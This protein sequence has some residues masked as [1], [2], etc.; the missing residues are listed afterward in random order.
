M[1]TVIA[2]KTDSEV[3]IGT[4]SINTFENIVIPELHESESCVFKFDENYIG[5]NCAYTIQQS[6][7][8]ILSQLEQ[9]NKEHHLSN[10][11]QIKVFFSSLFDDIR[12]QQRLV[13]QH[14]PSM[15]FEAFPMNLLIA[16]R[17]GIYKVDAVRAVY[18][19]KKYWAI[20]SAEAFALGALEATYAENKSAASLVKAALK[21]CSTFEGSKERDFKVFSIRLPN[22]KLASGKSKSS[23]STGAKVLMHR[24]SVRGKKGKS[25]EDSQD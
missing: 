9:E 4:D 3:A 23:S 18:E 2:V 10:K 24:G 12:V 5:L 8:Q 20:G 11:D 17:H 15:P 16:N 1:G 14:H 25:R 7:Q 13:P 22:L 19:Y 6:T 21:V